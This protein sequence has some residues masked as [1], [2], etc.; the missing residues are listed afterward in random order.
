MEKYD[1]IYIGSGN[2]A[3]Q[4]GR[5]LSDAGW[6]VLIIEKG[7]YGG[8]CANYG[9]NSKILLDAPYELSVAIKRYEGI[10]KK[11][12]FTVDWPSLMEFKEKRIANL[13]KFLE[14]KF[15]EYNLDV[16]NGEGVLLDNHRV[17]VGDDIYYGDKIVIATGLHPF[18]PDIP[19]KEFICDSTDFLN[20]KELPEKT[21]ILGAGFVSLEFASILAEAGKSVDILVRSDKVLRH[22]YQPYVKKIIKILEDENVNFHY[23][24]EA[25]EVSKNQD[26]F[27]VKTNNGLDLTGDYVL[28]ALGRIANIENIGLENAGVKAS[29]N[30][31]PVN[32]HMQTNV[33]NIYATGDVADTN[34]AKL[35]TVAIYQSKYLAKYL[36]GETT[37][38]ISYPVVPAVVFTLPRIAT[39][40]VQ[41]SYA[42]EHPDEYEVHRIEYGKSYSIELRN[43]NTAECT[44][45]TDKDKNIL[46]AEVYSPEAENLINMFT[47]I[48]SKKITLKELD[49]MIYAFPSSSSVAL[50]KLHNIH[51]NI[52]YRKDN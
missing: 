45:V 26:K 25:I 49:E 35:V 36:L 29:E 31:I 10:G 44:V 42:L 33:E 15:K 5:F 30:G 23:N 1:I 43:D 40:G 14:G 41:A 18:I 9:C 19:G 27:E 34:Q 6:K 52:G 24:Q 28:G 13:P 21:I 46:G 39:V 38:D 2:A 32:G 51:Y 7:L 20:I 47:F 50:Y 22:F 3:W 48:I 11:G 8:A 16:A 37:E 17:Q 4:G 12:D